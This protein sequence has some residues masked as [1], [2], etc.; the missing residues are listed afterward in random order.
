MRY[1]QYC[2]RV[3]FQPSPKLPLTRCP[4]R[5]QRAAAWRA[6]EGRSP[7]RRA[8]L[9]AR[10]PA[11][12]PPPDGG[13]QPRAPPNLPTPPLAARPCRRRRAHSPSSPTPPARLSTNQVSRRC[14]VVSWRGLLSP[15]AHRVA[16]AWSCRRPPSVS[17]PACRRLEPPPPPPRLPVLH[18]QSPQVSCCPP[19][20]PPSPYHTPL[21]P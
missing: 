18:S 17:A 11:T 12:L 7:P 2:T 14:V 19:S 6:P 8:R 3:R 21:S 15:A 16:P 20:P 1:V 13:V 10:R 5:R 4:P 9:R